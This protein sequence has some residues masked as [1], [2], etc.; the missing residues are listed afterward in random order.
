MGLAMK[1]GYFMVVDQTNVSGKEKP[2]MWACIDQL[3]LEMLQ[4]LFNGTC[5]IQALQFLNHCDF[6][7]SINHIQ[8]YWFTQCV[9]GMSYESNHD[10]Q[11]S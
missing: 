2:H 6:H 9:E 3:T 11:Y 7:Y 5:A 10:F 8:H 1:E 4:V